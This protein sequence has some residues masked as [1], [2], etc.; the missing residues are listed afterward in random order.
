MQESYLYLEPGEQPLSTAEAASA[1]GCCSN[2]VL[3]LFKSGQ[4]QAARYGWEGSHWRTTPAAL[5]A[6]RAK[7]NTGRKRSRKS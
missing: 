3:T 6:Y 7:K 4:I 1:L 5:R 2:T